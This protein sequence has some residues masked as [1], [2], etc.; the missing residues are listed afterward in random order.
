MVLKPGS[1]AAFT[2]AFKNDGRLSLDAVSEAQYYAS[3][4]K[5]AGQLQSIGLAV[6]LALGVGAT[7]GGMNTMF[8]AVARREREIGVLRVL[9]FTRRDILISFT[10][11]A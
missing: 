6:A 5:V 2:Q 1:G 10:P 3:Q 4:T 11:K 9:G 7:F 8:T